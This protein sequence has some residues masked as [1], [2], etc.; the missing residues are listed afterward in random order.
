M[1]GVLMAAPSTAGIVTSGILIGMTMLMSQAALAQC[2]RP[3][4]SV[5]SLQGEAQVQ[6]ASTGAWVPATLNQPLCPGDVVR[7]GNRSRVEVTM[8]NQPNVRLD[9]NTAL[10]IGGEG[11]VLQVKLLH[12]A[13]YFLSRH[14]RQLTVDTPFIDVAVEGTEFLVRV[15]GGQTL[16]IVFA[17]RVRASN[18][19]G[20]LAVGDGEAALAEAGR[21][22]MPYLI[23]RPRDAV[24]WTLFYPGI[25]PALADPSGSA[26]R[27]LAEP[28][29]SAVQAAAKGELPAA[30]ARFDAVPPSKRGFDFH[31]YR[32]AALLSVGRVEEAR[33]DIRQAKLS[34]P[35]DGRAAALGAVIAVA[36]ND[37][38]LAVA[39]AKRA[40]ELSPRSAAARIALSYAE[41]ARFQ[42]EAAR[43]AMSQA[44]KDEPEN[45]LAWARLSELWLMQGRRDRARKAAKRAQ[46][47]APQLARAQTVTGFAELAEINTRRARQAFQR[48]I[49]LDPANP[50]PRFGLGLT[51]IRDGN[52]GA[53]RRDIEIAVALDPNNA[54]LRSYLGK[55][56]FEERAGNPLEYFRELVDNFP[57]QENRLAAE[58]FVIAK[59][60]D[61]NDPTPWLYDAIRK[62]S[63]NRPIEALDDLERSIELNDNRA[64]YRSRE[65]LDEDRG[66]R[67]ASLARIYNDLGFEQ[68]GIS[69]ATRSLGYDPSSAAAHR[70]LSDVYAPRPRYEIARASELLQAQLLQDINLNPVQPSLGETDLNIIT[71][72][73]PARAGFN[74][75]TPLFERN[76]VQLNTSGLV[77]SHGTYATENVV[78]GIYDKVSFS[79]GQYFSS[80][81]G[82]RRNAD[83]ETTL[84]NVFA[85]AALTPNL[86]VQAEVRQRSNEQ[87]DLWSN[88]STEQYSGSGRR[89]FDQDTARLGLRFSPAPHSHFIT[90]LI[91]TNL[92]RSAKGRID[93]SDIFA[94]GKQDGF[95]G[96]AQYIFN[97]RSVD[98]V[99]GVSAYNFDAHAVNKVVSET[100]VTNRVIDRSSTIEHYTYYLYNYIPI[101]DKAR[102]TVAAS[103]DDFE[104]QLRKTQEF[105]PKLG[106]EWNILPHLAVRLAAL[107]TV[108]P[109]LV[110]S[111]TIQPTQVAGFNQ[112]F[113]D[114]NGAPSRL[115]GAGVDAR[116]ARGLY[117][118]AEVTRRDID[119]PAFANAEEP[120][121]VA[122]QS[123]DSYR[124]YLY[125]T[126]NENW[127]FAA[128]IEASRFDSSNERAD[129]PLEVRSLRLPFSLLYFDQNGIFGT[130]GVSYVNQDV[131]RSKST[132]TSSGAEGDGSFA[133]VDV[134]VGYRLPQR[135]GLIA[136]DVT[137][138]LDQK[139][140]YQDDSFREIG[141]NEPRASRYIPERAVL[142]RAAFNF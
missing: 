53:G 114:R 83:S 47:L 97:G 22:P 119:S 91:Y 41:Q 79:A 100:G 25:L 103:Y 124:G 67:G 37:R 127:A 134:G 107:Q 12:G 39:E 59:G 48:A 64:V 78:S 33:A 73:G 128:E 140:R 3:V 18:R 10:A 75:F 19:H 5:P 120:F 89:R 122:D 8:V 45:A 21:A 50:L 88:F 2:L 29:R 74:E 32:A 57:N 38:E 72:G 90:S 133:V 98:V 76:G 49:E 11:Q 121:K 15:D 105:S 9:Q 108:R 82:F 135:R 102:I 46:E 13:A 106:L 44:V 139:F 84:F 93:G 101:G 77:G 6:L 36:Q 26:A 34:D 55:A 7:A 56:Y 130:L 131:V 132:D 54:L 70:F 109:A 116:V 104:H 27:G 31:L 110:A 23:V 71:G 28:V 113:D 94:H 136:L 62:Q 126:L 96:E 129:P 141:R 17:G 117:L 95:Q 42:I 43:Q 4:G 30:F 65:L 123:E 111:Q 1:A 58:Q 87:G 40:V 14:P 118:G 16:V 115:Y 92:D 61:P 81:D 51:A 137:N 99:P 138:L 35:R 60:L 66:A 63:E 125:A 142:A 80:T 85:Q 69:E 68:L 24:Q 52:L 20:E 86:N 112:F